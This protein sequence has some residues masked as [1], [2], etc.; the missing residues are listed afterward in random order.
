MIAG[1]SPHCDAFW[2]TNGVSAVSGM[3][4]SGYGL[5][6]GIPGT[7]QSY[8]PDP[9]RHN[10]LRAERARRARGDGADPWP[11]PR[12]HEPSGAGAGTDALARPGR[13]GAGRGP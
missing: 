10:P 11:A 6:I 4:T 2:K 1:L 12:R 3:V 9:H 7:L 8:G 13:A 5:R